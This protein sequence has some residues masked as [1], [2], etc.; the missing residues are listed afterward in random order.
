MINLRRCVQQNSRRQMCR[1]LRLTRQLR[2]WIRPTSSASRRKIQTMKAAERVGEGE[3]QQWALV[4]M[5]QLNRLLCDLCCPECGE[6]GLSVQ[7]QDG[8]NAGFASLLSLRCDGCREYEKEEMPSPRIQDSQ[9]K[10][11]AFVVNPKMVVFSHEVGGSHAVL[12][13]FAAMMG[14][15][16]M[17]LKTF[18]AHDKKVTAAEIGAGVTVLDD[19]ATAIRQAY[20]EVDPDLQDALDRGEDPNINIVVSYDGT[21]MKRGFT[22]L[23]GVGICIDVL[24]GLVIDFV[25]LSKYCHACK[26]MEAKNLPDAEMAEWRRQHAGECCKNHDNS[27][28]AM[29]V[30]AAEIIWRRSE[31][32]FRFRYI[33]MLSDGDSSAF[34]AVQNVYHPLEVTKLE[35]INHAHKQMGTALRKLAKEERLGGRGTGRL[36]E[37]KCDMLQD[38]Y[39]NAIRSN[40]NNIDNMRRAIWAGLYHSMSTD[41]E[42]HHRQCPQGPESRCFYQRALAHGEQP[43][44]HKDHAS[45]TF[46]SID[47]T[48]K[49]IPVYRCMSD[50][51]FLRK[52][53][54]G[55]T[56]N[57]NECL[58]SMIWGRCPK[59]S[60]M[61]MKRVEGGVARAV[62]VFNEGAFELVKVIRGSDFRS[63]VWTAWPG[64][65]GPNPP[66]P[67]F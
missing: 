21:W 44:S 31:E 42:P 9:H 45:S 11:V 35:C 10:N 12:K 26:V 47:V 56:Q 28:K 67:P 16:A 58:N 50:E 1:L 15:P 4:H 66:L 2:M 6:T 62:A 5:Y 8:Q 27:S 48:H 13:T 65:V 64:K 41:E 25:V 34:K 38:Y 61:G 30:R 53:T 59:T 46:V 14:M 39:G 19:A 43:G 22:S 51:T 37:K 23:Y 49:M 36:T 40:T 55:G 20:A 60:F 33:E 63:T 24:T 54:H 29:E 7:I 32:K 18:Q 52:M 17:H 57:M 3:E